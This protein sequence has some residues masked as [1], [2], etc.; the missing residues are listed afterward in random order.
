MKSSRKLSVAAGFLL[1]LSIVITFVWF[2]KPAESDRIEEITLDRIVNRIDNKEVKE[3]KLNRS[4]VEIVDINGKKFFAGIGSEATRDSLLNRIKEHNKINTSAPIKY[5][6]EPASD[7][8]FVFIAF[9]NLLPVA[10]FFLM[11]GLTLAV[12]VYAVRALSRNKG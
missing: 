7:N 10:L 1:F 3:L 6:E 11:W 4:R 8:S 2:L 12:I 5:N 9:L